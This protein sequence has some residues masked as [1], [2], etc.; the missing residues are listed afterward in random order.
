[1]KTTKRRM[2]F[3]SIYNHTG[4]AAHLRAMAKKG[5][6]IESITNMY[7]TYRKIE[8]KDIHFSVSY[9]PRAS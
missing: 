5:W 4:I 3:F 2:E 1:M 7:W 8:P 6:M 9:Y